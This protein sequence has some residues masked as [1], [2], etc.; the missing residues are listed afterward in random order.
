MY[1]IARSFYQQG[2]SGLGC[3]IAST[4]SIIILTFVWI[5]VKQSQVDTSATCNFARH[6]QPQQC[7]LLIIGIHS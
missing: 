6:L 5:V 3:C 2:I 4:G 7:A 1:F